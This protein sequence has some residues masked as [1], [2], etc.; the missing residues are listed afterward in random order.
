[1]KHT[2]IKLPT[3]RG[4]TLGMPMDS[5]GCLYVP[6]APAHVPEPGYTVLLMDVLNGTPVTTTEIKKW[7]DSHP[8]LS[9]VR[10]LVLHG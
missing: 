4:R 5:A 2:T 6:D 8:V 3:S 1:M 10:R 9:K 7:T